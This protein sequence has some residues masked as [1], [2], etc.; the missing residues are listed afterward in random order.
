MPKAKIRDIQMHWQ[1]RGE[2]PDV[3]LVH[4]LTATLAFWY[5][6]P[7]LTELAKHFRVTVYDLRGHGYS[8]MTPTGYTAKALAD[9]LA[10]LL[11]HAGIER[12]RVLGHS[13]GGSVAMHFGLSHPDRTDGIIIC[14]TGFSSL[15]DLRRIEDWPGWESHAE[16]LEE[17][18][19]TRDWFEKADEIG[20]AAILEKTTQVPVQFGFRRGRRRDV[21]RFERIMNET[22]IPTDFHDECG[23]TKQGFAN[24]AAPT[25][26]VY[27]AD[28][29]FIRVADFLESTMPRCKPELLSSTGHFFLAREPEEFLL[30]AIPFLKEPAGYV[31]TG[32]DGENERNGSAGGPG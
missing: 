1:T 13:Y 7:V 2:G 24:V 15:R 18:G 21:E 25:L 28:S 32:R 12:A 19:A 17:L 10:A 11:D 26:A 22:S 16:Q 4:G 29:P 27:G 31:G 6:S 3:V 8:E 9:D 23:L 5:S 14:D 30:K 20:I